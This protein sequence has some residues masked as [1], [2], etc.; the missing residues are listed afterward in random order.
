MDVG[1]NEA[2]E[3]GGIAKIDD[4][5]A[6]RV[7]DGCANGADAVALDEDFA[8]ME[9]GAGVDLKQ[10]RGVE[11]YGCGRLLGEGS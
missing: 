6:L 3:Q 8:G 9:D 4:L 5:C 11:D 2:G 1:V 10:A 7:V